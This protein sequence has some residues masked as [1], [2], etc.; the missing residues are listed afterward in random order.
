MKKTFLTFV[1]VVL[2][3]AMTGS[4]AQAQKTNSFQQ[5]AQFLEQHTDMVKLTS[6]N[7]QAQVLLSPAWQGRVMTS[8]CGGQAGLSYGWI[9]FDLVAKG[10]D[11]EEK[12][13]G[14]EKHIYVFGGE[15]RFWLGPEGGQYSLFFH[16][17]AEKYDF[18]NWKT[19][20]LLDTVAFDVH[21]QTANSV[22]FKKSAELTNKA[23][24]KLNLDIK[25]SV[26]ILERDSVE[27]L[28]GVKFAAGV[29]YVAF[30]SSNTVTNTGKKTW[31]ADSG[32]PSIWMLGMLK[33]GEDIV[34][35]IPFEKDATGAKVNTDYFGEVANDRLVVSDGIA[36]FKGDGKYR[37]KIGIP[38]ARAKSICGSYSPSQQTLTVLHFNLPGD[39]AKLP[40][41]RSQWEHHETPYQG[42]M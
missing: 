35:A 17:S 21:N 33:P 14:L 19:P 5:D 9:N 1:F 37:A 13:V 41:V 29:E 42:E 30:T 36:F 24:T 23:G 3:K 15:E 27:K 12:R 25:R 7:G 26:E 38:A 18:D 22:T 2:I 40:Y 32:L 8:T 16:Q 28:I 11:P 6:S 4:V 20:A 10:V 31:A 39:A 34:M